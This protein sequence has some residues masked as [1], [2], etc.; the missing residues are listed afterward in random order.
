MSVFGTT[1]GE[2]RTWGVSNFPDPILQP[3]NCGRV[4]PSFVCD[5]DNMLPENKVNVIDD[6]L[7]GIYNSTAACYATASN[8][9]GYIVMMAVVPKMEKYFT[10]NDSDSMYTR[11]REAM[12]FS[13][14]LGWEKKWGRHSNQ[15]QEM[16]IILYSIEDGVLYTIAQPTAHRL[17]TDARMQQA[18]LDT[19]TRFAPLGKNPNRTGDALAYLVRKYSD[20]LQEEIPTN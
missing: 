19:I 8:V 15:C 20:H 13:Y 9:K 6:L 5:P 17:L 12:F 3:N 10:A 4:A 18:L 7:K 2:R 1:F 11:Y 16:V 14:F